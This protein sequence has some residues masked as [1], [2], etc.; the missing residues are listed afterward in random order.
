ME[1]CMPG[2]PPG[3]P[4]GM[5][6]GEK[7][8]GSWPIGRPPLAP[9]PPGVPP[10]SAQADRCW[11]WKHCSGLWAICGQAGRAR[12]RQRQ[13]AD[14]TGAMHQEPALTTCSRHCMRAQRL[15]PL[16]SIRPTKGALLALS[17]LYQGPSPTTFSRHCVCAQHLQSS[18]SIISAP[19]SSCAPQ[20]HATTEAC[21]A[22][23]VADASCCR[24]LPARW[25]RRRSPFLNASSSSSSSSVSCST[26]MQGVT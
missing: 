22:V 6:K 16:H 1:P 23:V 13:A 14:V 17:I 19:S 25:L 9:P 10:S 3:C 15:L 11:Q 12:V 18:H 2:T 26:T 21:E 5:P 7:D 24:L 8:R 20:G 4:G